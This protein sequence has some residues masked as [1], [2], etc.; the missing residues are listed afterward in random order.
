MPYCPKCDMEFIEGITVC[1]DCSSPL[2]ESKELAQKEHEEVLKLKQA[3]EMKEIQQFLEQQEQDS[4]APEQ[5]PAPERTRVYID[6]AQKYEDFKSS[7]SAFLIVGGISLLLLILSLTGIFPLPMQGVT[8]IIFHVTL[9][10][11]CVFSFIVWNNNLKEAKKILPEIDLEKQQTEAVLE[12][13][14]AEYNKDFIDQKITDFA[15][16]DAGVQ[17]LKR[18]AVIQDLLITGKDLPDP[19]YVDMLSEKIYSRL[20]EE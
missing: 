2:F 4:S 17:S 15:V 3:E 6:K 19:S 1:S 20:Y 5:K 9:I 7:A 18:F 8:K 11:M 13:F 16:L 14:Y 10:G 12:W